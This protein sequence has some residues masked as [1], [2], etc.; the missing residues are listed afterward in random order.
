MRLPDCFRIQLPDPIRQIVDHPDWS[1]M[2][3]RRDSY[4][5]MTQYCYPVTFPN[6]S[7]SNTILATFAGGPEVLTAVGAQVCLHGVWVEVVMVESSTEIDEE[8]GVERVFCTADVRE[9]VDGA[10]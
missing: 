10:A 4:T 3:G 8:D 2:G 1:P 5:H 7:P 6:G 9:L